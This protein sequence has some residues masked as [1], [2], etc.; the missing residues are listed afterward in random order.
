L[1]EL[2]LPLPEVQ[3]QE[4]QPQLLPQPQPVETPATEPLQQGLQ[5]EC[6]TKSGNQIPLLELQ[7]LQLLQAIDSS[8]QTKNRGGHRLHVILCQLRQIVHIQLSR[9]AE[10]PKVTPLPGAV[11]SG[12]GRRSPPSVITPFTGGTGRSRSS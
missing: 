11:C 5:Q 2:L 12:L 6:A 10:S 8:S 4:L 3:P 9:E 7:E 1:L